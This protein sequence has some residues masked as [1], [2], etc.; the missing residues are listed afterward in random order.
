MKPSGQI[1]VQIS[2]GILGVHL[3]SKRHFFLRHVQLERTPSTA[4]EMPSGMVRLHG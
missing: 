3:F 1:S 4:M 2:L